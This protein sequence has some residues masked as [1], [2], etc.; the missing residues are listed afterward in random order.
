MANNG[1]DMSGMVQAI[2]Y[3]NMRT[4]NHN[5]NKQL[6]YSLSNMR[7]WHTCLHL[8]QTFPGSWRCFSGGVSITNTGLLGWTNLN[9]PTPNSEFLTSEPLRPMQTNLDQGYLMFTATISCS[10]PCACDADVSQRAQSTFTNMKQRL[11][12]S[13]ECLKHVLYAFYGALMNSL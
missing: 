8:R 7:L 12:V 1:C 9:G 5:K 13:Y 3:V 4:L 10:G 2:R 6:F 11:W